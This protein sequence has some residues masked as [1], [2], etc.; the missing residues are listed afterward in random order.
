MSKKRLNLR[1]IITVVICLA[2]TSMMFGGCK[3]NCQCTLI[4]GRD[5]SVDSFEISVA[6]IKSDWDGKN[7]KD[8]ETTIKE[9][10]T[11]YSSVKC[12]PK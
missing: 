10:E 6:E 9:N 3:K 1:N 4:D 2:V 8:Y 12:S 7:C 5:G 11:Y